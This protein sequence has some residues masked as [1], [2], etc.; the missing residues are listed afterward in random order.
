M[1]VLVTG[2]TGFVGK[3]LLDRLDRPVVL[4]RDPVRA[5]KSLARFQIKA[6]GWDPEKPP[7]AEAFDGIDTVIHLAGDPVAEGRWTESKKERI[8]E[9]R[10]AGTRNLVATL[11]AIGR[12]PKVLVS[13]SAVGIYGDRG[14]QQLDE[15]SPPASDFL[16][17]VCQS[18]EHEALEASALGIRV[19]TVRVGI[20]LG[21]K[22]GAL[23]KMLTPFYLGLG[24]PL[25]SGNQYMPWVHI[26]DLV[27]IFLHAA[28]Y[29]HVKGPLNGVAPNPVT[30]C[31]FTKTLGKVIGRWTFMPS[32]PPLVLKT[33][34]GEFANVLLAS[35]RVYP[36]ATKQAGYVYQ[37][38]ELEPALRQILHR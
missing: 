24:S 4:S 16:A 25:G 19:T 37:Y 21:E 32:V 35:Q 9:S 38:P 23:G 2:A 26:D 1:R 34:L 31:E 22:G 7:P 13:A 14:D 3:R 20:V 12:G 10:V 33:M 30:N 5:E 6:F 27:G 17:E 29:G 15:S 28:R 36:V 18:W 8:R 11:R